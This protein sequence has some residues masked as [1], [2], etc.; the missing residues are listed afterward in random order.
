MGR[1]A[2]SV[3]RSGQWGGVIVNLTHNVGQDNLS[4]VACKQ[5]TVSNQPQFAQWANCPVL[6]QLSLTHK[7]E[8]YLQN[9]GNIQ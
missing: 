4:G 2:R 3:K 8:T 9:A 1:F 5:V 7:S 6:E